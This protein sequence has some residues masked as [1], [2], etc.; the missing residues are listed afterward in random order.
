MAQGHIYVYGIISPYQEDNVSQYGEVNSK[1]IHN[2]LNNNKEADEFMVHINSM[3]GDVYE[4]YAIHDILRATG[5]KIITQAEGLV[6]SIATVIFLSGDERLI[7]DNSELMVHNPWGITSGDSATVQKYAD[8][9]ST[10]ENKLATFYANKTGGD[11]E[12]IKAMMKE[13]TYL[14]ADEAISKGFATG[15]ATQIKAV[16]MLN[17]NSN[18]NKMDK[19]QVQELINNSLDPEKNPTFWDRILAKFRHVN[20]ILQDGAGNEIE[21]P[22]LGEGDEPKV[23][24][25]VLVGGV[26]PAESEIVM[27][28]GKT[29]KVEAGIIVE[30]IEKAVEDDPEPTP[31]EEVEALKA[32]LKKRDGEIKALKADIKAVKEMIETDQALKALRENAQSTSLRVGFKPKK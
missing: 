21:F 22:D 12:E 4:G 17:I 3:G 10:E 23:G 27:P 31:N 13:E 7:T 16:A 5:K 26:A 19:N 2:Q 20:L 6:A 8:S 11:V 18:K 1:D 15:K 9:L 29:L 30:I 25:K 28:D 32:E 24:D 14:T